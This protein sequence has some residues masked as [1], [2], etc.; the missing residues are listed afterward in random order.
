[1]R[2]L[3]PTEDLVA[4]G[5]FI[6]IQIDGFYLRRPISVC[7]WDEDGLVILYKIVGRGTARL[8]QYRPG[9]TLDILSGLG[10]GYTVSAAQNQDVW[11]VGGGVGVPPLYGLAKRLKK[12][13]VALGFASAQDVFYREEFEKLGCETH[14]AT[15]D[16]SIGMAGFVTAILEKAAYTYY[17]ACGPQGM[18]QAVH[19][20]GQKKKAKGQLSFEERM[21]CG[22]GACMGC[23]CQTL[24]GAKRI[25]VEGPVLSS[26]EV[27]FP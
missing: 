5:Q 24:T 12:P 6:N 15:E 22:F 2:L 25:C 19:R 11:L 4:P 20:V 13:R 16:G 7:D 21:G 1:M 18:L 10:N 3:G 26:E 17:F 14:I 27:V 9:E 8:T 23:S